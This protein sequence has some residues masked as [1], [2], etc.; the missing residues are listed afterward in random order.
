M[1]RRRVAEGEPK[2]QLARD[3]QVSRPTLYAALSGTGVYA[4]G[5][6]QDEDA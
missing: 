1:P 5:G 3:L 4:D 2:A 6:R